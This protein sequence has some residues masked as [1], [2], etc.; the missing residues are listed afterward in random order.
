MYQ[1]SSSS[2]SSFGNAATKIQ[3]VFRNHRARLRL[4]NEAAWK[5]HEKLDDSNEQTEA[6]LSDM[7]KKLMKASDILSPSV[8]KLLQKPGLPLGN[9]LFETKYTINRFNLFLFEANYRGPRIESPIK[10]SVFVDL[11]EAFQKGEILHEKYVYVIVHQARVILKTLP[12]V[13]HINLT[14]L[15]HI[16][17]IGDLHEQLPDL[18]HIFNVNGLPATDN[19]YIFNH[20]RRKISFVG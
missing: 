6:K 7:F 5:I 10:R 4:K 14:N 12:N 8:T 15:H 16:F 1:Q 3:G 13:N 17:I 20:G 2:S 18:L 11:I 19:P 9:T